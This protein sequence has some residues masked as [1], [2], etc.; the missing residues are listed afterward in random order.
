MAPSSS[1]AI[2]YAYDHGETDEFVILT[3]IADGSHTEGK[4]GCKDAVISSIS[5]R[6]GPS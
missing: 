6:I 1:A 4:D 2:D 3:V 5:V